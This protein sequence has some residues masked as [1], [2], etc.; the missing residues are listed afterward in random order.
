MRQGQS[1]QNRNRSRGRGGRNKGGNQ[2][3]RSMESNGPDVKIRGTATHIAEKYAT[4]ARDALSSS[5]IV[6]AEN[7]FQHAEHYNRLIASAQAAQTAQIT[8]RDA[9]HSDESRHRQASEEVGSE[10]S[11]SAGSANEADVS[12]PDEVVQGSGPQPVFDGLPAEVAIKQPMVNGSGDGKNLEAK[13]VEKTPGKPRRA[14]RRPR[15]P[16]ADK[17]DSASG[18]AED[19]PAFIVGA[20]E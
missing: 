19:L 17:G 6:A 13:P 14:A 4:L 8:Q 2:P 1:Q 5:D 10:Q 15:K 20:S 18:A 11:P 9:G 7:Y 12:V 16:A 3:N